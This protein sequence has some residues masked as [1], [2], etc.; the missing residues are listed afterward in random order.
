MTMAGMFECWA[1]GSV[2]SEIGEG[3][4]GREH[5]MM[6]MMPY[7][8]RESEKVERGWRGDDECPDR[9]NSK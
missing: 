1:S 3:R 8:M 4:G 6:M 2:E 5:I 7:V 9:W